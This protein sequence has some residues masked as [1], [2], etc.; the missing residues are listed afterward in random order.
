MKI[1]RFDFST[2]RHSMYRL[3]FP[4]LLAVPAF[5]QTPANPPPSAV[6]LGTIDGHVTNQ[7]TGEAIAGASV[8]FVPMTIAKTAASERTATTKA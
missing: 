6:P 3:L 5:A 4:L 7:Q 2:A 1:R 8:R